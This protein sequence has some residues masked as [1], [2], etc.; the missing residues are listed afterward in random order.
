MNK[1]MSKTEYVRMKGIQCPFCDCADLDPIEGPQVDGTDCWQEIECLECHKT[2]RDVYRLVGYEK[3][4]AVDVYLIFGDIEPEIIGPF[5]SE[6]E[7][8]NKALELRREHGDE[9]GI[10]MLN[11]DNRNGEPSIHTY[12]GGFFDQETSNE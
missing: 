1:P 4:D 3:T 5:Q 10:Y 2:W 11:V 6:D 9:D 7:R 12:C 8:D